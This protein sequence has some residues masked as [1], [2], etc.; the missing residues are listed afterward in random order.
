MVDDV[1]AAV[2][3]AVDGDVGI[4]GLGPTIEDYFSAVYDKFPYVLALIALITYML[5]VRTFRSVLLPLKAVLLNLISLAA[6]FGSIVFFWQ[7]GHGVRRRLRRRRR[8]APSTS[9]CPW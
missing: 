2:E 4:T 3:P 1:R 9:G 8:P 6:V 7:L 5:L